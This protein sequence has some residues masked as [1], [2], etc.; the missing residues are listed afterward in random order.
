MPLNSHIADAPPSRDPKSCLYIV[1]T[2]IGNLEDITFRAVKILKQVDLI[3]AEDTR[4]TGKLLGFYE[5]RTPLISY[6]EHNEARRSPLLV[7]K[8]EAG[9]NIALVS[10]A[11]TPTVADPGFRLIQEAIAKDVRVVPIPGVSAPITAISAA[12]LPTDHFTFLGFPSAKKE[13]RR[14]QL[15]KSARETATLVY[16][17]SPQRIL[18]FLRELHNAWGDR[19]AVIGREMTKLHE[20]FIRGN[21]SDII[22]DLEQRQTIKGECT[23]LVSGFKEDREEVFKRVQGEIQKELAC[24]NAKLSVISKKLSRKYGVSRNAVYDEALRWKREQR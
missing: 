21:L 22:M 11:G 1:A 14:R 2:P 10:D 18:A 23:L 19:C 3:A 4:R 17:L 16:Y 20:E 9:A 12:G 7:N 5:I 8:I 24:S 6:H 15:E 13:K